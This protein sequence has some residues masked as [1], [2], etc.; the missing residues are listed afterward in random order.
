VANRLALLE[1]AALDLE[2]AA[3]AAEGTGSP[4]LG[5]GLLPT[6]GVGLLF[7]EGLQGALGESG[8]RGAGD[9]LHGSEID[10]GP[11]AVVA[12]GAAGD[13]FAPLGGEVTKVLQFLGG[14]GAA[15]HDASCVEVRSGK[16]DGA[17]PVR[18]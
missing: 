10:V 16:R 17:V 11:G 14:K 15:C 2:G 12:A 13:D 9:L 8:G 3:P 7:E 5:T 1:L 18:V 6:Q 4:A